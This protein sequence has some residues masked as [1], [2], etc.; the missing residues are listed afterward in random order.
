MKRR[1]GWDERKKKIV[2]LYVH[3]A[4]AIVFLGCVFFFKRIDNGSLIQTL[5]VVAGYTYGPLL[6]LFAFGML[7][8][9]Q[10]NEMAVPIVCI[11]APV[12]CYLLKTFEKDWLCGYTIGTELLIINAA[13]TFIG[14]LLCSHKRDPVLI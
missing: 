6:A 8:K 11:A 10:L 7:T 12:A 4:F 3:N 2:R 5:L 13:L 1:E 9:R 14:L